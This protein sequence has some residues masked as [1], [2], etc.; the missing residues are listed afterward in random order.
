MTTHPKKIIDAHCHIGEIPPWKFYDLEHPVKPTVYDYKDTKAFL[1]NHMQEFKVE[2]ALVMSNYGV[3]IHELSFDLNDVVL[4][5]VVQERRD[6]RRDL[7]LVLAAQHRA[8]AQGAR[9]RQRE[10]RRRAEDDVPARRQ[11]RPGHVGRGDDRDRRR[12]LRRLREA[13]PRLP[14]PHEPRR[15]LGLRQL[16][17]ARREVRQ[18][19]Q[20]LPRPHGRRRV[21][22]H[23]A[24]AEVPQVGRG[25]LQGLHGHLVGGRLRRALA[26]DRDRADRRRR[27]TACSSAPT[28]R[29][30]TSTRSTGSSTASA[31]S[32]RSSRTT[33]SGA[34]SRTSTTTVA[35]PR[36]SPT[37][38]L[39]LDD[40]RLLVELQSFG[41]RVV[42]GERRRHAGPARRRRARRTRCSCTSAGC[43]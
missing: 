10:E 21:G 7:G 14:L 23:Q 41:V 39:S 29:G 35:E 9:A 40:R 5:A 6:P 18:A 34:T 25:G 28:S 30:R 33:S 38:P 22:P 43:R 3:P 36:A 4:E 11:P 32:R 20:D 16:H 26:A 8:H 1:K 42:G 24:R 31:G 2:R 13:R 37:A 19:L 15:Q 27:R 17:P 12:V